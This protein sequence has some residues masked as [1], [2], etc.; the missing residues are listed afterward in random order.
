MS[1]H[2]EVVCTEP[3]A[4]QQEWADH[5]VRLR[6]LGRLPEEPRRPNYDPPNYDPPK[7]DLPEYDPPVQTMRTI[8]E[9]LPFVLAKYRIESVPSRH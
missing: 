5:P 6:Q 8:G 7:S 3:D 1:L 4:F 9:I 2:I